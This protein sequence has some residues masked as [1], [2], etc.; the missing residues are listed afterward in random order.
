MGAYSLCNLAVVAKNSHWLI[1]EQVAGVV[2]WRPD[3][4]QLSPGSAK[5]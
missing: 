5:K 1:F 4:K 2:V 3:G